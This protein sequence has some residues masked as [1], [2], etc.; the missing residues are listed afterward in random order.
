MGFRALAMIFR[1]KRKM[2]VLVCPGHSG[3]TLLAM[4]LN[5]HPEISV[6]GELGSFRKR[7]LDESR[8]SLCPF[9]REDCE[10]WDKKRIKVLR[11]I[12]GRSFDIY[13]VKNIFL[14][15]SLLRT[16]IQIDKWFPNNTILVDTSKSASWALKTR[17]LACLLYDVKYVFLNRDPKA[18]VASHLRKGLSFD[19]AL[20]I[21]ERELKDILKFKSTVVEQDKIYLS[22]EEFV[23]DPKDGLERLCASL[24]IEFDRN[25]LNYQMYRHHIVGGNAGPRKK[26]QEYQGYAAS[27]TK[28]GIDFYEQQSANFFVDNRWKHEL[29][30]TRK[31]YIDLKFFNL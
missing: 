9:H 28:A 10:F 8:E 22:Y 18:L 14:A 19:E 7:L 11:H 27:K 2:V 23:N 20:A 6:I 3:S 4:C 29:S 13:P 26:A 12:W 5:C 21:V 24:F 1:K 31:S 16:F 30:F 15:L 25:M 17:R